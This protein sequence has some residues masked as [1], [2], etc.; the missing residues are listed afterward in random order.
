METTSTAISSRTHT[1]ISPEVESRV[2]RSAHVHTTWQGDPR[3]LGSGDKATSCDGGLHFRSWIIGALPRCFD[4]SYF[5]RE[6]ARLRP[7]QC[8]LKCSFTE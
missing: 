3:I 2:S 1:V 6:I 7:D 4:A 8:R 5:S